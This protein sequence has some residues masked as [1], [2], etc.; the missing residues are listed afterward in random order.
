M[1][2]EFVDE[3]SVEGEVLV[4]EASPDARAE[5]DV[6]DVLLVG[7][8][9]HR[10]GIAGVS[11]DVVHDLL[12]DADVCAGVGLEAG[13]LRDSCFRDGICLCPSDERNGK[14]GKGEQVF[15]GT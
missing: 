1:L 10:A 2:A 7:A 12:S 13:S 3:A 11:G 14:D 6:V 4:V 9:H 5:A 15:H 8:G